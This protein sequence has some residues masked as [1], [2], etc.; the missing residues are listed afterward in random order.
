[1]AVD[2]IKILELGHDSVIGTLTGA[3]GDLS[4]AQK[5][6][7]AAV[8]GVT[9][10]GI[11]AGIVAAV[12]KRKKNNGRKRRRKKEAR[13]RRKRKGKK[14]KHRTSP[15]GKLTRH[16]HRGTKQ[17]HYTKNRQP[18]I[19]LASGKARFIKKSSARTSRRRK[20]GRY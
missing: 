9:A 6:V 8:L 3:L 15:R 1:M 17:I 19:I 7:G 11:G 12:K 13:R 20:G 5:T 2:A 14:V 10:V 4:I 18:Y 16:R